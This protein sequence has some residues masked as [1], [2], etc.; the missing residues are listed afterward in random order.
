VRA[1]G[2][3]LLVTQADLDDV[4]VRYPATA[5]ADH[6]GLMRSDAMRRLAAAVGTAAIAHAGTTAGPELIRFDIVLAAAT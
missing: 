5:A 2:R 3:D 4:A 6:V 1:G